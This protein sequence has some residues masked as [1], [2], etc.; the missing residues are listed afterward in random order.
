MK[1]FQKK[2][3][4]FTVVSLLFFQFSIFSQ[5][6]KKKS[7]EGGEEGY[8]TG[9]GLRGGNEGGLTIKH[10]IQD[11]AAIEGIFTTGLG[12]NGFGNRSFRITGL[13]EIQKPLPNAKGF[14]YFYGVGAH[15][16]SYSYY[17][18]GYNGYNGNGYYDKHGNWHSGTYKDNYISV[19]LDAII[20]LEYQFTELPFTAGVDLKPYFDIINGRGSYFDFAFSLRY[21]IK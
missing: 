8:E 1:L 18:Y 17:S 19:G 12:Y 4:L 9:I 3:V 15:I 11:G 16:G 20:G 21:V 13:Y 6:D 10:F 14:D 7:E 5:K 2:T